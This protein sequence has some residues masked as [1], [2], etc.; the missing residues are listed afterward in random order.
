[1]KA[2]LALFAV[3]AT[4]IFFSFA[5]FT[6]AATA[7]ATKQEVVAAKQVL[8]ER[9][10]NQGVRITGLEKE[11]EQFS[12]Q[13]GPRG[14]QGEK[15]DT[16]ATGSQGPKGDTGERGPQGPAGPAGIEGPPG[17]ASGGEEPPIEEPP[18]EEGTKTLNCFPS[19]HLCGYPDATNTGPASGPLQPSGSITIGANQT[20]SGKEITGSVTVTGANS[21]LVNSVVNGT[22][23]GGNGTTVVQLNSGAANFTIENSI[24]AG[25]GSE[26]NAPESNVWNHY[27]LTFHV[28]NS[29]LHGTPDNIEGPAIVENSFIDVDAA[30]PKNHSEDI[31]LGGGQTVIVL[32]STLYNEHGET[33]L[34][35]GDSS[36]GNTCTVENSL[37]AGGGF[38]MGCNA[39]SGEKTGSEIIRNNHF[40][41]SPDGFFKCVGGYGM[42]Y[43]RGKTDNWT[44][45]VYDNNGAEAPQFPNC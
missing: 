7:P 44:G 29:Y 3:F 9:I 17:K 20:V 14:P 32:H 30:Y 37:L 24:I 34:I 18:A 23:G 28:V 42:S 19:P 41:R 45:N 31:Y 8:N 43:E 25:N 36:S 38:T 35:F 16:G 4:F 40:A 21:K 15:G 6:P 5:T 1:M 10:T 13:V 39:K 12:V 11:I 26:T 2:R 33:S 22:G 27:G